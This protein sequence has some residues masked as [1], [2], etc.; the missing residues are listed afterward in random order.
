MKIYFTS[1]QIICGNPEQ[2]A[3]YSEVLPRRGEEIYHSHVR[4]TFLVEKIEWISTRSDNWGIETDEIHPVVHVKD[5][6]DYN[7]PGDDYHV[8]EID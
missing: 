3:L 4:R 7:Y 2:F 6:S 5:V 1:D 8:R